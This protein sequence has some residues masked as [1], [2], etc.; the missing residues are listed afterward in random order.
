MIL[1]DYMLSESSELNATNYS[2]SHKDFG[3][4]VIIVIHKAC[5]MLYTP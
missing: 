5:R 4:K 3:W 2:C 1:V